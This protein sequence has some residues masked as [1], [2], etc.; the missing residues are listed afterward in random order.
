MYKK[1]GCYK[2]KKDFGNQVIVYKSKHDYFVI[3]K[4]REEV[5]YYFVDNNIKKLYPMNSY[6]R[7]IGFI[8][9]E[10]SRFIDCFDVDL[11]LYGY[12]NCPEDL[13]KIIKNII[14]S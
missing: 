2:D 5:V 4:D 11:S 13:Q 1:L 12:F 6:M 14:E 7:K 3:I 8:Y 9:C 10:E